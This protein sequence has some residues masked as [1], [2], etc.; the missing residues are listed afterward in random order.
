MEI[1]NWKFGKSI[2]DKTSTE[3]ITKGYKHA[4]IP[5]ESYDQI[6]VAHLVNGSAY[7]KEVEEAR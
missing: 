3:A 6:T 1:G 5:E 4:Y 7:S 2:V